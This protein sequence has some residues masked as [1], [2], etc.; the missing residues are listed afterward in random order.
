LHAVEAA[1]QLGERYAVSI[2]ALTMG[3]LPAASILRE[4][5]GMG[6]DEVI[7]LSDPAFSGSDTYTTA[8]TLAKALAKIGG[9]KLVICGKQAIDGDTGQVGPELAE[10]LRYVHIADVKKIKE[11][12]PDYLIAERKTDHG[13]E[14]VKAGLPALVTVIKE[15]NRPRSPSL[16]GLIRAKNHEVPVWTAESMGLAKETTGF[17][18]SPTRVIRVFTPQANRRGVVFT[19]N[20][21]EQIAKLAETIRKT[22]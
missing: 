8:Y 6:V 12:T 21:E 1:L 17:Q 3:P 18:A 2:T 14:T 15:I 19:G 11:L 10:Q 22:N 20:L 7:L 16:A 13:I 5:V 4:A 9:V